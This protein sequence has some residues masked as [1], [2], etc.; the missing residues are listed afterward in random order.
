MTRRAPEAIAAAPTRPLRPSHGRLCSCDRRSAG[1]MSV[2]R[3]A[4]ASQQPAAAS[5]GTPGPSVEHRGPAHRRLLAGGELRLR[6]PDLPARQ[7]AAARA[8]EARRHQAAPAR[9]LGDHPGAQLRLRPHEPGHPQLGPQRD[10]RDRPG[11]RRA[12]RG[13]ERLPRGDLQRGLPPHHPGRGRASASCSASSVS[14]EGSP[15]TWRP[16]PRAPSTR[17][18]SWATRSRTRTAPPSTT[19]TCSSAA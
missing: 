6:G 8:A 9:P 2:R 13:R 1:R 17:V 11:P 5:A 12:G 14:R 10:L 15:P 4:G 18:A 3:A 7:P 19:R 16:R